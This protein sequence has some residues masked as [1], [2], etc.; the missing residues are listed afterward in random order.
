MSDSTRSQNSLVAVRGLSF[1][2]GDN[3]IFK[4]V[5]MDFERGK[6]TA[7]MGPSGTGKT[8]LLKLIGGQLR[9]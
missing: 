9:P 3:K 2:R 4:D 5:S 7:I 1:S 8:T 6:I